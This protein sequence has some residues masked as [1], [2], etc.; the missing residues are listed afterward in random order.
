MNNIRKIAILGAGLGL[1][2]HLLHLLPALPPLR[3]PKEMTNSDRDAIERAQQKR[4][5]RAAKRR[6]E[7]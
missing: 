6:G 3:S 2:S 1:S 5:R 4:E 7:A